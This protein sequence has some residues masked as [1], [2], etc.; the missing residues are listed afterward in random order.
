MKPKKQ[1]LT[2]NEMRVNKHAKEIR[3]V[4]KKSKIKEDDYI[5]TEKILKNIQ[6]LL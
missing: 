4:L 3:E 5:L 2:K 6:V 1:K